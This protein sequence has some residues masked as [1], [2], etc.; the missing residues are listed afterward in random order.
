MGTRYVAGQPIQGA[1]YHRLNALIATNY[2]GM[3]PQN[4]SQMSYGR[5]TGQAFQKPT[6]GSTTQLTTVASHP[7][8]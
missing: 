7:F 6:S 5:M 1:L 2:A 8:R 4:V 3:G